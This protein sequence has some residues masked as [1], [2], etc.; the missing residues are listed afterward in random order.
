[1]VAEV[2]SKLEGAT[3]GT[4]CVLPL[5]ELLPA[6]AVPG[7][8]EALGFL[9]LTNLSMNSGCLDL[10]KSALAQVTEIPSELLDQPGI[11]RELPN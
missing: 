11:F 8:G 10:Y 6:A 9:A 2:V 1:V 7:A 5:V 3:A 4:E